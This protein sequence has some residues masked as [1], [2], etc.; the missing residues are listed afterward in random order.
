MP[1]MEVLMSVVLIILLVVLVLR[2][3]SSA[4]STISGAH[5]D[6][7]LT[8]DDYDLAAVLEIQR[9]C[10]GSWPSRA[11][12][13][14]GY[15]EQKDVDD[16]MA[17]LAEFR[18]WLKTQGDSRVVRAYDRWLNIMER[19]CEDAQRAIDSGYRE[20]QKA[21]SDGFWSDVSRRSDRAMAT[22]IPKP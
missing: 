9:R 22:K 1:V 3:I 7:P 17:V 13:G 11:S 10:D 6:G 14:L 2:A 16:A 12:V 8:Q 4:P 18:G 15:S 21:E 5:A 19:D 20:K